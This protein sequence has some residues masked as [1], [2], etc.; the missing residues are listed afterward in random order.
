MHVG[1]LRRA[2]RGDALVSVERGLALDGVVLPGTERVLR[3]SAGW[4]DDVAIKR[5][6][7][8]RAAVIDLLVGHWT[9]GPPREGPGS[10]AKV[11]RAMDARVGKDGGDLSVSV[12]VLIGADGIVWQLADLA[13]GCVHV[14]DRAT[15]ARSIGVECAWPGTSAQAAKLGFAHRPAK[16]AWGRERVVVAPLPDAVLDAWRWLAE[17]L[18]ACTHPRVRLPRTIAPSRPLTAAELRAA[19]GAVE[20]ASLPATTKRDAAGQLLGALD[21]VPGWRRWA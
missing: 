15:I 17:T 4:W 3:D 21:A 19:R 13:R 8:P 11:K 5:E 2:L 18:A 7:R 20:H 16:L 9:G 14:G 10:A 12:H 1:A 6:S